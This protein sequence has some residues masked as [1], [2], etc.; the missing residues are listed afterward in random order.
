LTRSRPGAARADVAAPARSALLFFA[1]LLGFALPV[2]LF[3]ARL[4]VIPALRVPAAD[5]ALAFTPMLA[6]LVLVAAR[7]GPRAAGA[8]LRSAFDAS[9]IRRLRWLAA[10]AL[11]PP[12]LYLVSSGLFR[13]AGSDA[14]PPFPDAVRLLA[15]FALFLVLAAGEE[16]GWMGYAFEPLQRR[17]G[18]VGASLLLAGPWWLGHLPSMAAIGAGPADMAWW[19]LGAAGLRVVM[20]WLY[21]GAGAS[22]FAVVLFHALLNLSRIALFPVEGTHYVTAYQALAYALVSGLAVVLMTGG[23]KRWARRPADERK[24]GGLRLSR[25]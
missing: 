11:L 16:V 18:A 17:F 24:A 12:A 20:A 15:M 9:S 14:A 7:E 5:L 4:G 2:W 3:G 23:R 1:V 22:L 6:A 13:L 10:A 21:L 19:L 8:L 25:K